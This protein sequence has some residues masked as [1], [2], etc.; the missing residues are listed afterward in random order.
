MNIQIIGENF[1]INDR[2]RK[3]VNDKIGD[4]EKYLKHFEEDMKDATVK[5]QKRKDWGYKVN[6]NMWLPGK[7]EIFAEAK[8]KELT[9]ALVSLR[10]KLEVQ[11]KKY[12][13]K[14]NK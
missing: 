10:E 8:H 14:L 4:L 12:K 1:K 5:I 6:F 3:I 9:P 13:D 7:K 2:I 11:I